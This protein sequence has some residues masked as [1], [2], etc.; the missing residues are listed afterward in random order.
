M[1]ARLGGLVRRYAITGL[2]ACLGVLNAQSWPYL[3]VFVAFGA[4]V[5]IWLVKPGV[6]QPPKAFELLTDEER[7]REHAKWYRLFP[8]II[9]LPLLGMAVLLA[10]RVIA[11]RNPDFLVAMGPALYELTSPFINLLR[12][13]YQDLLAHGLPD[14]AGIV[15]ANYAWMFLLF[16]LGLGPWLAAI[17]NLALG[18]HPRRHQALKGRLSIWLTSPILV[19]VLLFIVWMTTW[20]SID[21]TDENFRRRHIN[22]NVAKYDL[23]FWDVGFGLAAFAAIVPTFYM[24]L[25]WVAAQLFRRLG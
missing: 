17:K 2:Y 20:A 16:Y 25:R 11:Q 23:F 9:G 19:L 10:I 22:L 1:F 14:R 15:A 5:D 7:R 6:A 24:F 3:L 18:N 4:A 8:Y 13:H 21:Y 12:V